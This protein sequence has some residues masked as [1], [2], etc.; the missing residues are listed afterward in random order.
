[1]FLEVETSTVQ[2]EKEFP[3]KY[4]ADTLEFPRK[5]TETQP[6]PATALREAAFCGDCEGTAASALLAVI[7]HPVTLTLDISKAAIA[8]PHTE[9]G[10]L[11]RWLSGH[12][13]TPPTAALRMKV[14]L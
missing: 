8:P 6:P 12:P 2:C 13:V 1:M 9:Q 4:T 11:K 14:L 3:L 7:E 10:S 5:R